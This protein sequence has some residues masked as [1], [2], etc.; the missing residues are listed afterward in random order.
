MAKNRRSIA[1]KYLERIDAGIAFGSDEVAHW[2]AAA[3]VEDRVLK[4]CDAHLVLTW[5]RVRV[6]KVEKPGRWESCRSAL[7]TSI[8]N[9]CGVLGRG[10]PDVELWG[11]LDKTDLSPEDLRGDSDTLNYVGD[12]VHALP[13]KGT[14]EAKRLALAAVA[15]DY[16]LWIKEWA[17]E[18]DYLHRFVPTISQAALQAGRTDVAATHCNKLIHCLDVEESRVRKLQELADGWR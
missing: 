13:K 9:L 15:L 3:F 11:G 14:A 5:Q 10:M 12:V 2:D 4:L 18:L 7:R 1:V 6:L 16:D 8:V 17:A